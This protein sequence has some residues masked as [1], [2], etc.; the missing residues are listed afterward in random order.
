MFNTRRTEMTLTLTT[1]TAE[2]TKTAPK[3]TTAYAPPRARRPLIAGVLRAKELCPD[4]AAPPTAPRTASDSFSPAERAAV[5]HAA[6]DGRDAGERTIDCV[7]ERLLRE[8]TW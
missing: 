1:T 7:V 5:R 8:L 2:T 4:R 3:T 6:A